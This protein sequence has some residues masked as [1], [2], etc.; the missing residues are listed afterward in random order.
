MSM[1]S[2]G[3]SCT[4]VNKKI[5]S[6]NIKISEND[7]VQLKNF[8]QQKIKVVTNWSY[9]SGNRILSGILFSGSGYDNSKRWDDNL[10]K[11][12]KMNIEKFMIALNHIND[13]KKQQSTL[14]H[15]QLLIENLLSNDNTKPYI[16][17]KNQ[18]KIEDKIQTKE[19][20]QN[21]Q[22]VIKGYKNYVDDYPSL[23]EKNEINYPK[24]EKGRCV[25]NWLLHQRLPDLSPVKNGEHNPVKS[26]GAC[27][28][29]GKEFQKMMTYSVTDYAKKFPCTVYYNKKLANLAQSHYKSDY[30]Q[31]K[32]IVDIKESIPDDALKQDLCA[33][34]KATPQVK[35]GSIVFQPSPFVLGNTNNNQPS[36]IVFGELI[37]AIGLNKPSDE[38]VY[39]Y[40]KEMYKS[41]ILNAI[42]RG[43]IN[44]LILNSVGNG[45][46]A[47]DKKQ[48]IDNAKA[49]LDVIYELRFMI[50]NKN[51]KITLLDYA[52][53]FPKVSEKFPGELDKLKTIKKS[54]NFLSGDK[55]DIQGTELANLVAENDYVA[56]VNA[57]DTL[58]YGML[59]KQIFGDHTVEER[60][61]NQIAPCLQYDVRENVASSTIHVKINT[62]NSEGG[63]GE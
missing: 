3:D 12:D 8:I 21:I 43:I 41:I 28:E 35:N 30:P 42:D 59:F 54:L 1:I 56:M 4:E 37:D 48:Q 5:S 6:M 29:Y 25:Y 51:L 17:D 57:S 55:A 32:E 36:K 16:E 23:N 61:R 9:L 20:I 2:N 45:E 60:F 38:Y 31:R 14:E 52:K 53:N 63:S 22:K 47:K 24:D 40:Y 58:R 10:S 46:F 26:Q 39:E 50:K 27:E 62:H 44:H 7:F 19:Y 13:L 34:N 18:P 15:D 49:M 33:S 11:N